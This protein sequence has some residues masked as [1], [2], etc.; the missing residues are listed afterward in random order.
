MLSIALNKKKKLNKN[1]VLSCAGIVT[2]I[3]T[4]QTQLYASS[5]IRYALIGLKS[6]RIVQRLKIQAI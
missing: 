3:E 2:C 1:V 5:Q 4:K 6:I